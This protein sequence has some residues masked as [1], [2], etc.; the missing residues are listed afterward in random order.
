M[1]R[2]P[3]DKAKVGSLFDRKVLFKTGN[4]NQSVMTAQWENECISL[5]VL[6]MVRVIIAQWE[7]ECI[8]LSVLSMV[9]VQFP[10]AAE[11]FKRF[12]TAWS[13]PANPS[14]FSVTENSSIFPQWHRTTRGYCGGRSSS[15]H[16]QTMA[17]RNLNNTRDLKR[18]M[19]F[20][21]YF[22]SN[23][24]QCSTRNRV[25]ST[26]QGNTTCRKESGQKYAR[27]RV[28]ILNQLH[29]PK[30]KEEGCYVNE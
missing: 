25:Q 20:R 19:E 23:K 14:R 1:S 15:N 18:Y 3:V 11:Y 24:K 9:R 4:L 28:L 2:L 7:N 29:L 30:S 21:V 10:A 16:G 22:Y 5:S 8:S 26:V 12:F 27:S 6:S 13:R 17:E